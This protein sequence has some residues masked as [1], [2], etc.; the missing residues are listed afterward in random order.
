MKQETKWKIGRAFR[1]LRIR[2]KYK[3]Q[4]FQRV[5]ADKKDLLDLYNAINHTSYTNP[6]ELEITTLEDV[7][8]LSMKNDLSFMISA[9]LNLYEHQSTY[10]PNMPI[11][12]LMYF[13]RLY[14]AYIAKTDAN[15][16]GRKRIKLPTPDFIVFYNGR[17]EMPDEVECKLSDAFELQAKD[18]EPVLECRAR[19]LNIN[20]GHNK[21]LLETCKRLHD[22]AYFIAEVNNNLDK[23]YTLRIAIDKAID[24]CISKD[25]LTDILIKCRNEVQSM[26]LTEFDVNK[27]SRHLREEGREEG[28]ERVNE[29]YALLLD[30]NRIEDMRRATKDKEYRKKLYEEFGLEIDDEIRF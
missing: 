25:I 30:A 8:Y 6:D 27:Y 9:T 17:E 4:F 22:Y 3:D 12:G 26:L 11:R 10:N 14:E 18:I 29:L 20:Y 2:K 1:R 16:Y 5:F 24:T 13:A 15:I 23:K 7:I 21:E 28:E 19:M